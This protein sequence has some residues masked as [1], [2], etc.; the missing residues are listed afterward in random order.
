MT[1]NS[2]H[3]DSCLSVFGVLI[4]FLE[5]L[6]SSSFFGGGGRG[7]RSL[8]LFLPKKCVQR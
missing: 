5:E 3:S 2:L 7:G 1:Q 4:L 6:P 8:F